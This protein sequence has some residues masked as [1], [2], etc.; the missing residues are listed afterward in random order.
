LEKIKVMISSTVSDLDA[1]RDAAKKAFDEIPLVELL[2]AH[3]FNDTA[4]AGNSRLVTT[5]M[6]KDCDLYILILGNKFGYELGNG[7]SATEIEF[8][9]AIRN[10]PT[11]ILVFKKESIEEPDE[12]QE[13]FISRVSS[14]YNGYWRTSFKHT[15]DLQIYIKNAFSR[16]IKDRASIGAGLNYLDHFVRLAR[17]ITPEQNAEVYYKVSKNDV[18]LEYVF[19]NKSHEIHFTQKEIYTNFWGCI[20]ELYNQFERWLDN[21]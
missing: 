20:Y 12:K 11:K 7:K 14:Y 9:T 17:Q 21:E 8:D 16:W 3:P 6:A 13:K 1:E 5:N 10:D 2:G 15:H 19:F 18:E 4:Y